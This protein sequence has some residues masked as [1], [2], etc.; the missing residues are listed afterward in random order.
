V[1]NTLANCV[2]A[3]EAGLSECNRPEDRTIISS[4][5]TMLAPLLAKVTIGSNVLN[6]LQSIDRMFGHTWLI[7]E[8]PFLTAFGYWQQFKDEYAVNA[9]SSKAK[10]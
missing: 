3:F 2:I 7:D 10:N 8:K 9:N 4:Y 1:Q 5:L 6:E